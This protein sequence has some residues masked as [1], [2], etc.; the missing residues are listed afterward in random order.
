ME[1]NPMKYYDY[2]FW[3]MSEQVLENL[4]AE[5]EW[6]YIDREK[7]RN[8]DALEFAMDMES[9]LETLRKERKGR[10]VR[11]AT[12]ITRYGETV[13]QAFQFAMD[14]RW[15]IVFTDT[16][17]DFAMIVLHKDAML[18]TGRNKM[19][20]ARNFSGLLLS[21]DEVYFAPASSGNGQERVNV[22]FTF[23]LCDTVK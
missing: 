11:S 2:C 6:W 4:L 17:D 23:D 16:A 22:L 14:S 15:D 19:K 8:R 5:R 12:R 9:E 7:K 3:G 20:A 21:A 1:K 18:F 13:M 10:P